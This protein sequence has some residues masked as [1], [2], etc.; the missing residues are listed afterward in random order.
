MTRQ[1]RRRAHDE[2]GFTLVEVLITASVLTVVLA[3]VLSLLFSVQQGFNRQ[4]SRAQSVEQARLAI[5]QIQK[6]VLSARAA[7]VP[8]SGQGLTMD[9]YTRTNE[10]TRTVSEASQCV[11]WRIDAGRL[12]SRRWTPPWD[13]SE[14]ALW[15]VVATDVTNT[16]T[17]PMFEL[18]S[19]TSPYAARLVT[20]SLH[21][22]AD[23]SSGREVEID[24]SILG[25]NITYGTTDPCATDQPT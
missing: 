25:R 18:S 4:V 6:E 20:L 1:G 22:N 11:Q 15:Q 9:V 10:L 24:S 14:A 13:S 12:E 3:S 5:E 8:S 17:N 21:T 19:P 2:S 7:T 16:S 23:P